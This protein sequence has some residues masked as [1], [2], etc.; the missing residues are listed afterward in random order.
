MIT[1]LTITRIA[2][3]IT[4]IALTSM[5][6]GVLSVTITGTQAV[7]LFLKTTVEL[8]FSISMVIGVGIDQ[9]IKSICNKLFEWVGSEM[10]LPYSY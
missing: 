3:V 2:Q 9:V 4:T 7:M 8:I 1:V 6:I 5:G 10:A